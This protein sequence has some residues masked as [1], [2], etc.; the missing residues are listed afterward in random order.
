MPD[1]RFYAMALDGDKRQVASIGSNVGQACGPGSSR[2]SARARVAERLLA[3]DM[4]SGWGVRTF[5]AGQP[6]YNPVGYHTG[7]IW[8]HDN[9]LIAAGLKATAPPTART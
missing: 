5:A 3:P 1:A 4:F 2:P 8:P 6:G 7:S 9:A